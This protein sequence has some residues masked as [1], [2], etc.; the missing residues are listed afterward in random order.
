[1]S[2]SLKQLEGFNETSKTMAQ[3]TKISNCDE[4][5]TERRR[6]DQ[7]FMRKTTSTELTETLTQ[8]R[9]VQDDLS[10]RLSLEHELYKSPNQR[11]KARLERA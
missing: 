4:I 8:M 2:F 9:L 1:M 10:G 5:K 11:Q 7:K 3:V 6:R